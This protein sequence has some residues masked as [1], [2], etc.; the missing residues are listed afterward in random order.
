MMDFA[1]IVGSN[2]KGLT[3]YIA[4]TISNN[5]EALQTMMQSIASQATSGLAQGDHTHGIPDLTLHVK[6]TSDFIGT[7]KRSP[8]NGVWYIEG[9]LSYPGGSEHAY[10]TTG[11]LVDELAKRL[12][13]GGFRV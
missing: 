8:Q 9:S 6:D 3:E 2:G 1:N 11:E 4:E 7:Y 12:A 10:I 13:Y 5:N